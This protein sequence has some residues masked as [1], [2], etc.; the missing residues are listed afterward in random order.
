[1]LTKSISTF[2]P[3]IPMSVNSSTINSYCWLFFVTTRTLSPTST[4]YV[5]GTQLSIGLQNRLSVDPLGVDGL[6]GLADGRKHRRNFF[7]VGGAYH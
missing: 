2:G 6:G 1:M 5:E 4:W 7:G 3:V